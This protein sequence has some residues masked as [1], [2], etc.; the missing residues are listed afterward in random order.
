MR[1]H[2]V[3]DELFEDFIWPLVVM[4]SRAG[5]RAETDALEHDEPLLKSDAEKKRFVMNSAKTGSSESEA[6]ARPSFA[7]RKRRRRV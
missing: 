3:S 7:T 6:E 1:A 2:G 4:A 5:R